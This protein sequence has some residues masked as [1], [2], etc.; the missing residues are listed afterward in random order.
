MY[1]MPWCTVI[2]SC[3]EFEI[4]YFLFHM[5][6]GYVFVGVNASLSMERSN[7]KYP[8][9]FTQCVSLRGKI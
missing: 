2:Y 7:I 6:T 8:P 1:V 4:C 3:P 5:D 9:C